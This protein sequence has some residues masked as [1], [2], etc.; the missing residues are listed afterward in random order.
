MET[1]IVRITDA[2]D[3]AIIEMGEII[4]S[5]G[6]VSFPTETV[7]GLGANALDSGAAA[8]I[9]AAKGRPAD[10]PLIV[11]LCSISQL[12]AVASD[13]PDKAYVLFERFAPGPLTVI[14]KKRTELPDTVTAGLDTVAVRIPSH[15]VARSLINAAGV[16]IAAPSANLSGRPSPTRAEHVIRDMNGRIDAIIDGGAC[17][18]GVESTIV[19][20]T[21]GTVNILR[22][23][24]ITKSDISNL[25]GSVSVDRHVY[26]MVADCEHPKSPGMKYRHYSPEADVVVVEGDIK[27]STD[28]I[29]RLLAKEKQKGVMCGV[30]AYDGCTFD[31]EAVLYVGENNKTYA[32][33]LFDSLLSFDKLGIKKVFAQFFR[34]DDY[35]LAVSNR[36][37]KA[38]G[39]NIIH[40]DGGDIK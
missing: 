12:E 7:Y 38:A 23:G 35:G 40:S 10:N 16:P 31:S 5:G 6:L 13:I 4:R 18:V 20:L 34:D 19:E 17:S 21:S 22:P 11:H 25:F 3:P 30:M 14:L 36:L 28:T 32:S 33:R 27:S 9:F 26:E 8:K 24:G 2:D 15:P 29:R 37:F 1:K 39:G